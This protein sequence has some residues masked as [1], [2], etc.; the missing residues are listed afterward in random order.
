MSVVE[1]I[2]G[3]RDEVVGLRARLDESEYRRK[4][5]EQTKDELIQDLDNER[6][7]HQETSVLLKQMERERNSILH[8]KEDNARLRQELAG[9]RQELSQLYRS[10][11][12]RIGR[13]V[14]S[15][16]RFLRHLGRLAQK[17]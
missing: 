8:L 17:S 16:I 7:A 13:V 9:L 5:S 12:W 11:T 2:R 15:P 6:S 3:L 4:K 1:E 10:R 14:L